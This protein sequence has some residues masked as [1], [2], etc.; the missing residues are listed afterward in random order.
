MAKKKP[1]EKIPRHAMPEQPPEDR[2]RNFDEVPYGYTEE[3]AIAEASRCIQ[4]KKPKCIGGCPVGVNIPAFLGLIRDGLFAEAAR[5]LKQ[6]TALPA[7]C[8]RVCPQEEQCEGVCVLGVKQEP[9]AIG[10]LERFAADYERTMGTMAIPD[11]EP[12]TGKRVAIVGAGPSG[13]T[14]GK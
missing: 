14:C 4:C 1:K 10:R 13:L 8:G 11:K 5:R 6:D 3:L 12:P 9:V 2:A 7:V